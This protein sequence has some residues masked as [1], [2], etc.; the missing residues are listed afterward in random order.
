MT[1]AVKESEELYLKSFRELEKSR[2]SGAPGWFAKLRNL[3]MEAFADLGF[4]TT[5]LEDWKYTNLA[6]LT[7]VNF[8]PAQYDFSDKLAEQIASLPFVSFETTRLVFVNGHYCRELSSLAGLAESVKVTNLSE[9]LRTGGSSLEA[10]LAR[11]ADFKSHAFVALNTAFME[12]GGVIEIPKGAV[13]EK[14]LHLMFISTGGAEPWV[15]YPRNLVLAGRESQAAV[16]ETY[17]SLD[18][19][20]Y[21]NNSVTEIVAEEGARVDYVKVQAESEAAFHVATVLAYAARNA[22][23]QTNSLQFGARLGREELSTVLDGE[24]A[25]SFLYGLY[26]TNGQQLLDN[27][28]AIDHTRPHCSSREFYKGI[29]D[30]KSTGV[31]NGKILVRKDAQ[32]TDSKQSD[33]NLLLSESAAINT[34]PQLEIFADDVKCTHGATVGQIDPEAIFYLRSRGIGWEDAR[35]LLIVAFA[36]EI[37]DRIKFLPLREQLKKTLAAKMAGGT[38]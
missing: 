28:S 30:G 12:D 26:V 18:G 25:E 15:A 8:Q 4:P 2:A 27:H 3:G 31:F 14:P 1:L 17:A 10:H 34:K 35:N 33:K 21:F 20:V 32:K 23:I 29:L 6:P 37:I 11:Y 16:I 9:A 5:R 36:N 22:G 38:R 7:G 13:L 24:G 19:N